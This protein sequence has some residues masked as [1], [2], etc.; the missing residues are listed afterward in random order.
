MSIFWNGL[1]DLNTKMMKPT[2]TS[3]HKTKK[4]MTYGKN[5]KPNYMV[6]TDH[7]VQDDNGSSAIIS[8]SSEDLTLLKNISFG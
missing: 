8:S 2:T 6:S 5:K 1:I 4:I 7:V 3:N